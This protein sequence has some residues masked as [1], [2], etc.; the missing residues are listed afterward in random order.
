MATKTRILL[1]P[2]KLRLPSSS[3]TYYS[4]NHPPPPGPFN[5]VE[6]TILSASAPHIPTHGFTLTTLSLGAKDA[7]YIDAS[8]NLFPR[9]AF[10]LV[11]W[12]LY[13]QRMALQKQRG[14]ISPAVREG[15]RAPGV[16]TKVKM[17]TWERLMGNRDVVHRWQEALA[18][19]ALPSNIPPSL[20]ELG[21]LS[22]EIW[23]LSG[24][25]SVDSS[26]YTKRA[27]LS[28]IYAASELFMT[29]DKTDGYKET[30]AFMERRFGDVQAVGGAVGSL[31]QWVGFNARAGLNVLRSKGARI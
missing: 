31:G 30:R 2:R 14:I 26:W 12:H 17:L 15:E 23:Y 5:P 10:A 27:S 1:A 28:S 29:T 24:D 19:M 21:A 7:G 3:R 6:S 16:G 18:L 11:Q 9:G 20:R 13:T 8:T 22:D 25:T 4:H